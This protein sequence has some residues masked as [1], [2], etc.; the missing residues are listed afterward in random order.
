[1][2]TSA[3][4]DGD[5]RGGSNGGGAAPDT[6][7]LRAAQRRLSTTE[8]R[9]RRAEARLASLENS[10]ALR[11]GQMLANT[12]RHPARVPLLPRELYRMWR[13]RAVRIA[14][15]PVS[16]GGGPAAYEEERLLVGAPLAAPRDQDAP[17]RPLVAGVLTRT[18]A[19]AL[20]TVADVHWLLPHNAPQILAHTQPDLVLV[21]AAACAEGAWLGLGDPAATDLEA[22]LL[23]ALRG[24]EVRALL[25]DTACPPGLRRHPWD[26]TSETGI[27]I[28][29][30]THHPLSP[31]PR[32]PEPVL[33]W[34]YDPRA[35]AA[36]RTLRHS[37]VPPAA[38][39][40]AAPPA[41]APASDGPAS[42]GP[43]SDGPEPPEAQAATPYVHAPEGDPGRRAELMRGHLAV[44][45]GTP[46]GVVEALACGAWVIAPEAA[47]PD[48][49]RAHVL[50]ASDADQVA[51][52]LAAIDA[53]RPYTEVRAALRAL[54]ARHSVPA[55]LAA[56]LTAAHTAARAAA[57]EEAEAPAVPE[58]ARDALAA[59]QVTVLTR[60]DP[61]AARTALAAQ[62]HPAADLVADPDAPWHDLAA[63]ARTPWVAYG[64]PA[65]W[66]PDHLAD[67][68]CAAEFARADAVGLA[69]QDTPA[70]A[71]ALTPALARR[72]LAASG[73]PAATWQ[74]RHGA[75]LLAVP[76]P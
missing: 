47:V 41:A 74:D 53:P 63:R 24:T 18:T 44:V 61:A 30:R 71:D 9:L 68:L 64:D 12:A 73:D 1:V 27:G 70:Y 25:A 52:H 40:A 49:L 76:K 54:F 4:P 72:A 26:H 13:R 8:A 48:D 35:P 28:D 43:A 14:P 42:D 56:L 38:P 50:I 62:T 58:S 15:P 45:A 59:R 23:E 57:G 17:P 66:P 32:A 5:P 67:L 69:A 20:A 10:T 34:P 46:Q 19:D 60:A 37:L 31:R 2:D 22:R 75:R 21:E 65:D 51:K 29:L 55:R 7:R 36:L 33:A 11:V 16:G 39:P 6:A 3:E